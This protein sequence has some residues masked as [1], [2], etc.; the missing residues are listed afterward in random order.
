M[1][2]P[3]FKAIPGPGCQL[4][5]RS[6]SCARQARGSRS[7]TYRDRRR[8][9]LRVRRGDDEHLLRLPPADESSGPCLHALRTIKQKCAPVASRAQEGWRCGAAFWNGRTGLLQRALVECA[10]V[11][12]QLIDRLVSPSY[13]RRVLYCDLRPRY[14]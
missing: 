7:E 6:S 14:P 8:Y 11:W 1:A 2:G 4:D 5:P 10:D 3:W 9:D 12:W 13:S